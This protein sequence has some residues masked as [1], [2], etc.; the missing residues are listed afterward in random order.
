VNRTMNHLNI[1]STKR[2]KI[3]E[4]LNNFK[5]CQ[6][7][8]INFLPDATFVIDREGKVIAWNQAIEEMTGI[9][10]QD[11]LGKG[12]YEYAIPF[13]GNR[14]PILI[15]LI[16]TPNK[17]VEKDYL[18]IKNDREALVAETP[19]LN[20]NGKKAIL[21]TKATP[22][23]D[24]HGQIIGAIESIR[25]ITELRKAEQALE[26][27]R[28]RLYAVLNELP[29]M[30][31][32]LARDYSFRFVNRFF[33]ERY[34]NPERKTCYELMY[35]RLTPCEN[36]PTSKVFQTQKPQE[37]IWNSPDER[38]YTIYDYPF[39]DVDGTLLV[40]EMGI[41]ITERKKLEQ[42][43]L[44]LDRLNLIGE[45]AAGLAHEIRNP[46]TTVRGFLQILSN[47]KSQT[48]YRTYYNLMIEELDQ[49]NMIITEFLS[50]AKNKVVHLQA[51]NLNEIVMSLYPLIK[52]DALLTDKYVQLDLG[53]IPVLKLDLKEIRQLILNL[54]RNGLEAMSPG[55]VLTISTFIDNEAVVLSVKDQG[56]GIEPELLEKLGTPFL[57]TK[58]TGTG[59][60]L[61]ICYSIAA[62]HHAKI[63]VDTDSTGTCFYVRFKQIV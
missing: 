13:H 4:A 9:M 35:H 47:K 28:Q 41:D 43:I 40:L 7:D 1:M 8:I 32:L 45:M 24:S 36:C 29:A 12:N 17:E 44:R 62:R 61:P 56:K 10:A 15:D 18:F 27:E 21:W 60:G 23:Y 57:T 58:D 63:K 22:L 42:E 38:T 50:L 30:L 53:E 11:I 5:Q 52:A 31:F 14:K 59:L 51:Q 33:Q 37:W 54:A 39:I 55:G 46:M 19:L 20:I 48:E 25:D 3:E 2:R 6:S 26:A 49:A 16:F 34:G